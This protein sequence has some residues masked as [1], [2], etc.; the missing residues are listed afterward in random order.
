MSIIQKEA[1]LAY[2]PQLIQYRRYLHQYPELSFEETKTREF[3]TAE[4]GKLEHATISHPV[5]N[6]VLVRFITG[7]PGPKI[8]LR[9]DI[10]ALAIEEER[11]DIDFVSKN[12]G[13]MHACGHD[14]HTATLM[15][16]CHYFNE[17]FDELTGEVW[18]IFQHAEELLPG[19]AQELV[20]TGLFHELDFMYGHHLWTLLPTGTID[21]KDGAVTSNTDIYTA[22]IFGKGGHS[23]EPQNCID[24]VVIASHIVT[25]MQTVVARQVAPLEAGVL[26]NTYINGGRKNALNV[27]PS[28]AEIGGSVRSTTPE[29]RKLFKKSIVRIIESNCENFNATCEI[30]YQ[31]G[32]G[33]T[34]N[35]LEKTAFVRSLAEQFTD[36]NVIANPTYL[37]GEDFSAFAEIIPAT[38][39]FI[40]VGNEE[41]DCIYPHHHPKFNLDEDGLLLGL[42]MFVNVVMNYPKAFK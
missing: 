35:N 23:S 38:F 1:L 16:A 18:A 14:A 22:K 27:I 39:A 31:F 24:P 41:K 17:H 8:G 2:E 37:A 26:S 9:G 21:L 28:Y 7:K 42:Q 30:D 40:G 15:M 11:D 19:G 29:M 34:D 32:Y 3:I 12:P 36:A 25:Q 20:A 13:K 5:G 33:M 10:D 6:S 4:I